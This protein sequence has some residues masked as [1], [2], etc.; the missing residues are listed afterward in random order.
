MDIRRIY[1][2]AL[3]RELEGKRFF[4]TNAERLSQATALMRK[5]A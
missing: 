1:T 4:E 3:Q 5:A 2:Y